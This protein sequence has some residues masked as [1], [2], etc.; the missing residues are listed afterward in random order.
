MNLLVLTTAG[1]LKKKLL[2]GILA[3]I[4]IAVLAGGIYMTWLLSPPPPPQTMAESV[5]LL[6]SP[7]FKRLSGE[8]KTEYMQHISELRKQMDPA[9]RQ[10]FREQHRDDH[11]YFQA[12][13]EVWTEMIHQHVRKFAQADPAQRTVILDGIL[14]RIEGARHFSRRSQRPARPP[15]TEQQQ[16]ERQRRRA[17]RIERFQQR[18]ATG[19][20][21]DAALRYEFFQALRQRATAK[22]IEL[23]RWGGR[24]DSRDRH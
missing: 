14:Q 20:A 11:E 5:V 17:T 1:A 9:Q 24:R 21:Q 22:G 13:R 23:R 15:L 18:A 6:K 19:N 12:R 2:V 3:L 16:T 7:R 8:R 10:V 4:A